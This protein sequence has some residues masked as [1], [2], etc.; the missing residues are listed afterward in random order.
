MALD[1]KA[2]IKE[3]ITDKDAY[4]A[5]TTNNSSRRNKANSSS[6]STSGK[7]SSNSNN[8]HSNGCTGVGS[9][10][11]ACN[12]SSNN[13]N[14]NGNGARTCRTPDSPESARAIA[15]RSPMS[16][17]LHHSS[18]APPPP[19]PNRNASA[20]PV[21]NGAITTTT[22]PPLPTPPSQAALA[23]AA[24]AATA[25]AVHAE[26]SRLLGKIRKFLGSLVQLAQEVHPEVSDRVRA[27]VL[28]LV[29]SSI[30]IDEFRQ[31]LQE[32]IN[33]PLR[34]YVIPLLKNH[35]SLL[36]REIA[37]LARVTN[38]TPLQYVT[39]NENVVMEFSPHGP[40]A[41]Y[42][43]MFVHMDS[44]QAA[45]AAAV[46]QAAASNAA[47]TTSLV[48]KRRASD[49]LMEHH[50]GVQDW[51]DYLAAYPPAKRALHAHSAHISAASTEAR[52]SFAT[53]PTIFDYSSATGNASA[54]THSENTFNSL[55]EKANH[56]EER[57]LR[58]NTGSDPASQRHPPR[59]GPPTSS[60]S[61]T[62]GGS[63]SATLGGEEEWKNIHTMLNCISAMVDKTKRAITILQQR[64]VEPQQPNYSELT[65]ASLVEIRRQT[66]EKVA[67]FKRNAE[68]AVNQVK[69]QAV[70]EIQRAVVAA[71]TRASEVMAQERLRM[72]KFF[73]EMSRHSSVVHSSNAAVAGVAVTAVSGDRELDN[74]SPSITAGQNA[75]WNCGR[76]ATET[77]SG[78]NL[79]RYCG[80]FCQHKDWE[81][82][83]QICGTTRSTDLSTKHSVS[84]GIP[85]SATMRGPISRSPP[86]Q[87]QAPQPTAQVPQPQNSGSGGVAPPSSLVANG[88]GSK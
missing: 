55:M 83:H 67:E 30:S 35:I 22:P 38:Q 88:V 72:E 39:S 15:P 27:L 33:L 65:P 6:N 14:P 12:S 70:I 50:N 8:S 78:C 69:R 86:N 3:E 49:T 47:S 57:D 44:A 74:K 58:V 37:E 75:C 85:L 20:S 24:A 79:A 82:H 63:S 26:Q 21:V 60:G 68:E 51:N 54:V 7:D 10:S 34:P 17:Q 36:Q 64:G 19:R 40:S 11:G 2:I 1:G 77:C 4:E 32:T 42:S 71:E 81:H 76:K 16:P 25:A 66:E 46:A 80:A 28:S 84:Q 13:T 62:G 45:A 9:A 23:A 56:R 59:T 31:T 29:S 48:F 41:E 53:Q 73:V 87:T 52:L 43:D 18:L 61:G 5:A